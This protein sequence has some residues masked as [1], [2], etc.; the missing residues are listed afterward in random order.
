VRDGQ[1][2]LPAAPAASACTDGGPPPKLATRHLYKRYQIEVIRD[3]QLAVRPGAFYS[4]LGPNGCGKTTMLRI[5]CGLEAPS[6]GEVVI[7]GD[8]VDLTRQHH[9]HRVAIVFQEPRLLPWKSIADNVRLCLRSLGVSEREARERTRHYLELVGLGSFMHYYPN[10]LSGGMQQR[11]SIARALAVE[12]DVLLMDEPFSAL[13]A[14]NRR[15]MQDETVKLWE[16]T[17]KTILF[18]THSIAEAVRISTEIAVLTARPMTIR[19][20][21]TVRDHADTRALEEELLRMLTE[22]VDRQRALDLERQ[23]AMVGA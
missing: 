20:V 7:D 10:R 14:Q 16:E 21:V 8:V 2:S 9:Q 19:Q 6:S 13:D 23:R 1:G 11:A 17:H 5:L 12:P 22:E 18:V 3:L 4:I 15:I